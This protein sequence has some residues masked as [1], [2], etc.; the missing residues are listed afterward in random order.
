MIVWGSDHFLISLRFQQ[1]LRAQTTGKVTDTCN[2]WQWKTTKADWDTYKKKITQ[3][4][5][6][7]TLDNNLEIKYKEFETALNQAAEASIPKL[8]SNKQYNHV[9][10]PYWS[11]ECSLIVQSRNKALKSFNK[12]RSQHNRTEYKKLKAKAQYTIR[13]AKSLYWDKYCENMN[14]DTKLGSVWTMIKRI[15]GGANHVQK[16]YY[17]KR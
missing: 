4:L 17:T 5:E 3:E 15:N 6:S 9:A 16:T 2:K 13:N 8:N 11:K 7:K 1:K 14:P 10:V 12:F